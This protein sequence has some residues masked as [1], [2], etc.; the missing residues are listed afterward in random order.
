MARTKA[1]EAEEAEHKALIFTRES[2]ALKL[3]SDGKT[4]TEVAIKLRIPAADTLRLYKNYW[5]L[6]GYQTLTQVEEQLGEDLPSF[7]KLFKKMKNEGMTLEDIILI[8]RAYRRIPYLKDHLRELEHDVQ[9][10][11]EFKEQYIKEYSLIREHNKKLEKTNRE[12]QY[13]NE[14]YLNAINEKK[15]EL[16]TLDSLA[17]DRKRLDKNE[18]LLPEPHKLHELSFLCMDSRTFSDNNSFATTTKKSSNYVASKVSTRKEIVND[19]GDSGEKV[20]E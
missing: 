2:Q 10:S 18:H 14:C 1:E 9:K 12:L 3:F 20:I 7:L 4:P 16:T 13:S 11:Y 8:S 15:N 17:K 19:K 6:E 5:K